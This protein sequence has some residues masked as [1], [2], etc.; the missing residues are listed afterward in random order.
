M[1]PRPRSADNEDL[2]GYEGLGRYKD[3][4][5]F[6][7]NPHTGKQVSLKTRD[8]EK[9]INLHALA[10]ALAD[11]EY[12]D[13]SGAVL[14]ERLI[15]S[16]VPLSKGGNIHLCDL[17]TEWKRDLLD[18]G[19][20]TIKIKRNQGEALSPQTQKDYQK[21]CGMITGT[22]NAGFPVSSPNALRLTRAL[23]SQWAGTPTTYNHLKSFL[24]R[25]YDHAVLKGLI[26]RNPMRDIDKLAVPERKVLMPD[27][28]YLRIVEQFR[29]HRHNKSEHDGEWRIRVADLLYMF[30]QQPIDAFGLQVAQFRL[31]VGKHGEIDLSRSK[32]GVA[33]I[34]EMNAEMRECVDWLLA[35]RREQLRN[36]NVAM[37][38]PNDSLLIY[39]AY[40]G[41]VYKWKPLRH[42][43]FSA[44]WLEAR[45]AAGI[46]EDYWLMDLRKK[47][48]TAEY[49]S[50]G[51]NDKG[52]HD[53][54]R[55][56]WHYRLIVPPKRS[57]NTLTPIRGANL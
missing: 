31:D 52:L 18:K 40:M 17:I 47:G 44:W 13:T 29:I 41:R 24:G 1:S 50:Q 48:L 8:L 22:G 15:A 57:Q 32:T 36:A 25:V 12:G 9:A 23:I 34:I 46:E 5:Y 14:A 39:P 42:R 2:A 55:M 7:R 54:E 45:R 27:D 3:G 4:R 33:G 30:S 37:I 49:L 38:P 16:N 43:T 21:Y 19:L 35:W 56:K 11:K 28:A 26:D 51:E 10:K 53:S 20:V 6:F